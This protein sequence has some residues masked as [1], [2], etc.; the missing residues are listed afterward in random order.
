MPET[1]GLFLPSGTFLR[2]SPSVGMDT[3]SAHT[4]GTRPTR[5]L[6]TS[7]TDDDY[8]SDVEEQAVETPKSNTKSRART[9]TALPRSK[10]RPR[11]VRR[12]GT[13]DQRRKRNLERNRAAASKCRERKKQWQDGLE[14]RKTELEN[15]YESLRGEARELAEDVAQLKNFVMAHAACNDAN[16]DNWIRNQAGV[17]IQ[18]MSRAQSRSHPVSAPPAAAA[19][20]S[21]I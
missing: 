8:D 21:A 2:Q 12:G 1:T 16:I 3:A 11:Q 17:F 20:S 10:A 13:A 7:E 15:R 4:A 5:H 18:R 19:T 9:N 6:P 14:R